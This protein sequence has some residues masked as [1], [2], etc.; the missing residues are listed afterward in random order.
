MEEESKNVEP[1]ESVQGRQDCDVM[2]HYKRQMASQVW[3]PPYPEGVL[4]LGPVP[5]DLPAPAFKPRH[6]KWEMDAVMTSVRAYMGM[7]SM[8]MKESDIDSWNGWLDACRRPSSFFREE[9]PWDFEQLRLRSIVKEKFVVSS[10]IA[11]QSMEYEDGEHIVHAGFKAAAKSRGKRNRDEEQRVKQQQEEAANY[12]A[13]EEGSFIIFKTDPIAVSAEEMAAEYRGF[14]AAELLMGMVV[15]KVMEAHEGHDPDAE[16]VVH[17]YRQESG[18]YH[19][20]WIPGIRSDNT[21]WTIAIPRGS[22]VYVGLA[23]NKQSKIPITTLRAVA[24]LKD[25]PDG[26]Q[27]RY[28]RKSKK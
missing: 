11:K 9:F 1:P 2:M 27:D 19:G 5:D 7:P 14:R 24:E 23:F 25:L 28:L 3:C 15:G 16:L 26:F 10:T 8:R 17:R 18:I 22:V 12:E 4:V 6:E 21:S 20:K 13:L